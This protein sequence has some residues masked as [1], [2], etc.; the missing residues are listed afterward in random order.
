M[1]TKETT[2]TAE[3]GEARPDYATPGGQ[4]ESSRVIVFLVIFAVVM[5]GAIVFSRMM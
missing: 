1:N 4:F 3:Q 5:I 2:D